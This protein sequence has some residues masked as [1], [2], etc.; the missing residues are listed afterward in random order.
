MNSAKC[1]KP[2]HSR[3]VGVQTPFV[4]Q[5]A[6]LAALTVW[7]GALVQPSGVGASP[8]PLPQPLPDLL[9]RQQGACRRVRPSL[10]WLFLG[11]QD[12]MNALNP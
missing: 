11:F 10:S 1:I 2:Y 7:A 8:G 12:G 6:V 5:R 3:K 4:K 9:Q